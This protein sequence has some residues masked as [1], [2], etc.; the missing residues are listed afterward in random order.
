MTQ[1]NM[2]PPIKRS[3]QYNFFIFSP[4]RQIRPAPTGAPN[5]TIQILQGQP[6]QTPSK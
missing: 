1:Y 3:G 5:Q 2:R 6:N 4:Q